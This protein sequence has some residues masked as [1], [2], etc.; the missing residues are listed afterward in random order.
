M[1]ESSI[2]LTGDRDGM[3]L[4][5]FMTAMNHWRLSFRFSDA[6]TRSYKIISASTITRVNENQPQKLPTLSRRN[7]YR[8]TKIILKIR[9]WSTK[10][11]YYQHLHRRKKRNKPETRTVREILDELFDKFWLIRV[12]FEETCSEILS[13]PYPRWKTQKIF[14]KLKK[15][16]TRIEKI[17]TSESQILRRS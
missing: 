1:Y 8:L 3:S 6:L 7:P 16:W 14:F 9:P 17:G 13:K 15:I 12:K 11:L 4:H 5:F 2:W 10:L